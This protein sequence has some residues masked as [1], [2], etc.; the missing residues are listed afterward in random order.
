MGGLDMQKEILALLIIIAFLFSLSGCGSGE[1]SSA[2]IF[3]ETDIG[4]E[5]GLDYVMGVRVDSR[6][7]LVVYS[8]D[9]GNNGRYVVIDK[10]RKETV[11]IECDFDSDGS[12]FT[13]DKKD[14]LYV[15]LQ[16]PLIDESTNKAKE[17]NR[18]VII[19]DPSG[20]K[21][22]TIDLG[23]VTDERGYK[24]Y[25]GFEID[26]AGNIYLLELHK[27]VEVFDNSGRSIGNISSRAYSYMVM[28]S[29]DCLVLGCDG[30]GENK[31]SI[32]KIKTPKGKTVWEKELGFNDKPRMIK[33]GMNEEDIY[34]LTDSGVKKYSPDGR[35]Q[36]YVF[37]V[38]QT[39]LSGFG[40]YITGMDID[41]TGSFYFTTVK[42]ADP[43]SQ[44]QLQ[45]GFYKYSPQARGNTDADTNVK[46]LTLST[47]ETNYYLERAI[48]EFQS[49]H[50]ST[51][52]MNQYM[53]HG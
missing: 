22:K 49:L 23:N 37:D 1:A 28:D 19:Y 47:P 48:S 3:S 8:T 25:I 29:N 21:L 50:L 41:S 5:A 13:L 2:V 6:D 39:G 24:Q 9:E 4:K 51:V 18:Q 42:N 44:E 10:E 45:T 52:N 34:V 53:I 43:G 15:L 7:R 40:T 31:I 12:V 17:I 38:K 20:K 27:N 11:S 16:R 36:G 46:T 26:S 14:N 30:S 32:G 33:C 35:D